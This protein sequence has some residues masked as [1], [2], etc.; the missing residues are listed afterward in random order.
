MLTFHSVFPFIII[1][2]GSVNLSR[3]DDPSHCFSYPELHKTSNICV[4]SHFQIGPFMSSTSNPFPAQLLPF[5]S[6]YG[7]FFV[8]YGHQYVFYLISIISFSLYVPYSA[9]NYSKISDLRYQD[10]LYSTSSISF[11]FHMLPILL[12]TTPKN[13]F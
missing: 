10:V 2:S 13:Q 3:K 1:P 6:L 9:Y 7:F 5:L 11:S 8:V 12:I 4:T